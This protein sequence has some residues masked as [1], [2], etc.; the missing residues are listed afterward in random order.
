MLQLSEYALLILITSH[1]FACIWCLVVF[2]EARS[3]FDAP[4]IIEEPNWIAVWYNNTYAAGGL[5]PIGST[6]DTSRYILSLFWAVQTLTSIGYGNISPFTQAE[7]WVAS[8][9]M[10]LAGI[11]WAYIIGGLVS[12]AAGM[13]H[14]VEQYGIRLDQANELI[15]EFVETDDSSHDEEEDDPKYRFSKKAVSKRI[16]CYIHNQFSR[17]HRQACSSNLFQSFPVLET[18]TPEL[19][20]NGS[21]LVMKK[22]LEIVPYL[23]SKYLTMEEQSVIAMQCSFVEFATGEAVWPR[24][25]VG[26]LGS[27]VLV[28]DR[29][30]TLCSG[31]LYE[32]KGNRFTLVTVG[33]AFG[34]N[35]A[36]LE[37]KSLKGKKSTL[38]FLTFSRVVFIPR[39]AILHVL[40]RN[41]EAWKASARWKYLRSLILMEIENRLKIKKQELSVAKDDTAPLLP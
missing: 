24:V 20:R 25:G 27:G 5:N 15:Q 35:E 33:M 12:V 38:R 23:S 21:L 14:K 26:H 1:W 39:K 7:W 4:N 16:K 6:Q 8:V 41:Q 37:E 19:Q 40:D 3:T 9:I 28:L 18:L 31:E 13:H 2:L 29:G 32:A 36:L 17:S 22:Y 30:V 10:L 34:A 11:F